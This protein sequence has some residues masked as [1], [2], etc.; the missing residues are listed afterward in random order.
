MAEISGENRILDAGTGPG[1]LAVLLPA[2]PSLLIGLD[3]STILLRTARSRASERG[4]EP[5]RGMFEK[6]PFRDGSFDRVLTGF[7]LRDALDIERAVV[8]YR[9]V[10]AA[11]GRLAVVDLGKPDGWWKRMGVSMYVRYVMPLLAWIS[12]RG[13]LR[14]NPWRMIVPTFNLLPFNGRLRRLLSRYFTIVV[15]REHLSGGVIV[16]LGEVSE[17]T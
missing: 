15:W 12:L 10:L 4:L 17:T 8:E 14:G 7:A 9:R 16:A 5:V 2:Q 11:G 13:R 1:N 6:L 3:Y